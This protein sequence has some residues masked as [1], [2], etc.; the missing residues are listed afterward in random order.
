M[1]TFTIESNGRLDRTA[2]Y[3]NGEQLGGL[4]E[5]F[6]NLDEEGTFDAI[7]QYKGTDGNVHTKQIFTEYLSNLQVVEPT[8]T[9]EEATSLRALTIE[10]DGDIEDT[11]LFDNVGQLEGVVS[12]FIHIKAG[13]TPG[14]IATL[15]STKK[16]PETTEFRHD[17]AYRNEDGT[18]ETEGVF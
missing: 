16:V 6:L 18:V 11:I 10:S 7:I 3:F 5:V 17:I 1:A 14:G 13:D 2:V 8:F 9:E 4:R 15:F 12:L